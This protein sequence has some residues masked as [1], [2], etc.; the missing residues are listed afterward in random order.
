MITQTEYN[1]LTFLYVSKKNVFPP[2]TQFGETGYVVIFLTLNVHI[3]Y[4]SQSLFAYI[5]HRA[6]WDTYLFR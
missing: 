4:V 3:F 1:L 5:A 2:A 6:V